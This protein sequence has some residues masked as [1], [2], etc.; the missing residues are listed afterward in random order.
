MPDKLKIGSIVTRDC[1]I[2]SNLIASDFGINAD[3]TL[4]HVPNNGLMKKGKLLRANNRYGSELQSDDTHNQ[5]VICNE[6]TV[7]GSAN[8]LLRLGLEL[9]P[10]GPSISVLAR[11]NN[12]H[13]PTFQ[14]IPSGTLV[15][16]R[17]VLIALGYNSIDSNY[18]TTHSRVTFT[19]TVIGSLFD[20]IGGR[21]LGPFPINYRFSETLPCDGTGGN[22][23]VPDSTIQP[24]WRPST[25]TA[26]ITCTWSGPGVGGSIN[27]SWNIPIS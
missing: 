10:I 16:D 26:T 20:F 21:W 15:T 5:L 19:T 23:F 7:F 1:Q 25:G 13:S 27:V 17:N 8:R 12:L 6:S 18:S 9:L 24:Y 4:K 22:G 3:D 2:T 11:F 14:I